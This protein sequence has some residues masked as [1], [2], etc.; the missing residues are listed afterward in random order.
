MKRRLPSVR[1]R[2]RARDPLGLLDLVGVLRRRAE[3]DREERRR[4]R[5][6]VRGV[7]VDEP[8]GGL[9][10]LADVQ[11]RADERAAHAVQSMDCGLRRGHVDGLAVEAV[12][13]EH[14]GE[15]NRDERRLP[16]GA[17]EEHR[18]LAAD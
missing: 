1:G 6:Q 3:A 8:G 13:V 4:H 10:M 14:L 17:G 7:R 9:L 2:K 18:H 5:V 11:R 15:A 12:F 16:F